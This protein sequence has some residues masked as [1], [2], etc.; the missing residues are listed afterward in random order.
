MGILYIA[1]TGNVAN[2]GTSDND[3]ADLTGA[4]ATV[5]GSTVTLDGSPDLSAVSTS[6][7]SQA[8]IYLADA[9]NSNQK[10]FWI[11]AADDGANTVTVVGSPTGV[12]SS[13]WR[14]GGRMVHTPANIEG[15]L[16]AGDIVQF[17]DSPA[18]SAST[19]L[20]CRAAGTAACGQ[21]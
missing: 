8:A 19:L 1:T 21:R 3:A 13:A 18:S 12:V 17:N 6:G 4:A 14:I 15:A 10:V 9:N 5:S 20:T 11:T 16:R 7:P 2:S